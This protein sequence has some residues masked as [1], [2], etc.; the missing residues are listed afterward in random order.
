MGQL[1][2]LL[3]STS[4]REIMIKRRNFITIITDFG[5]A[6]GFVGTMKGV[7]YNINPHAEIIDISHDITPQS[8]LEAAF[9]LENSYRYFPRGTIHTIVVDPGVGSHRRAVAIRTEGYYFVA[10]DNG[11]LTPIL[12]EE[13]ALESV[14][15]T[16]PLYFL[17]RISNTFHGRD[18]FAPVAAYLS[19][20]ISLDRFGAYIDD[21]MEIS[22]PKPIFNESEI[23]GQIVYIDKF[24]NL[25]TN[26]SQEF[27]ESAVSDRR[28]IIKI[29]DIKL[30]GISNAYINMPEGEPLAVFNSFDRLEIAVNHGSAKDILGVQIGTA[31]R[32]I[33]L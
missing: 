24:G 30:D 28:F 10:P 4:A 17:D 8:I 21:L 25:I 3:A 7:I 11:I 20:G 12:A 2:I 18:I 31:I 16:N 27:F 19:L 14:E 15:L 22:I 9:L 32:I 13:K 26:I 29:G 1:A 33:I 5:L 6:D 23:T